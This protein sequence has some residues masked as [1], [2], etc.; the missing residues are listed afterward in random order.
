MRYLLGEQERE[1][2]WMPGGAR[3]EKHGAEIIGEND[4]SEG[5]ELRGEEEERDEIERT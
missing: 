5:C 1:N 2:R 4:V 3:E